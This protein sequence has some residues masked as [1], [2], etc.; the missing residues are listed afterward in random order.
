MTLLI[1]LIVSIVVGAAGIAA[2]WTLRGSGSGNATPKKKA[3]KPTVDDR[4]RTAFAAKQK[5]T[6]DLLRKVQKLAAGIAVDVGE[7]CESVQMANTEL[8]SLEG[9]AP[10]IMA[11]LAKV[12]K[13]NEALSAKLEKAE[14]QLFEQATL[15][16]S[17][18]EEANT[19]ALTG[20]ANRRCFDKTLADA[21]ARL[22]AEGTPTT[23]MMLDVDHFKKFNDMHGHQAGDEV[24]KHVARTLT[25]RTRRHGVACRYGGEEFAIVFSGQPVE[26]CL[27]WGEAARGAI[28]EGSIEFQGKTLR[29][30]ASAGL[31]QLRSGE[32]FELTVKRA[33]DALYRAKEAGRNRGFW[34][35]GNECQPLL[36]S[37]V[38]DG[39]G[40]SADAASE[41]DWAIGLSSTPTFRE[42]V[43]RRVAEWKRG[44]S[45]VSI[46]ILRVDNWMELVTGRGQETADLVLKATIQFLKAS[47][48]D[49]DNIASFGS[50]RFG[51][52]FPSARLENTQKIAER[53]RSAIARC[54]VPSPSGKVNFTVS[55][56]VTELALGDSAEAFLERA[57]LAMAEA[58]DNGGN[59]CV[60]H[61][62]ER[63]VCVTRRENIGT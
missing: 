58:S 42:E 33:D 1:N 9:D 29:V 30:N 2:G 14:D 44:G 26:N 57:E 12:L 32:S 7:H 6:D 56:G 59:A 25:R 18:A 5:Q 55:V 11:V 50:G 31:A 15:I 24:L 47:V 13:A 61:D 19:D 43:K 39:S 45:T 53:L 49:M 21:Q 16:Q 40:E 51:T 60:T 54:E 22:E 10:G 35:D 34:H 48:R 36:A 27:G 62:G 37:S 28:G 23:V 8:K 41:P 46:A 4:E 20:V 63:F 38:L 17:A 52:M 3:P